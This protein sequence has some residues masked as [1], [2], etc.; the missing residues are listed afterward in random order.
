[1]II[2]SQD[3]PYQPCARERRPTEIDRVNTKASNVLTRVYC[4]HR[5]TLYMNI[6]KFFVSKR[7]SLQ[8]I[9]LD[10]L[11]SVILLGP[12]CIHPAFPIFTHSPTR[13]EA[14]SLT[15]IVTP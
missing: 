10:E 2:K 3:G 6:V 7:Q 15:F 11:N 8:E 1:M 5:N 9:S 13:R 4:T 12:L 14:R